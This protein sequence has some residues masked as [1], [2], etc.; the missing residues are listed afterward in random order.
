MPMFFTH[1]SMMASMFAKSD[2]EKKLEDAE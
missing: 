2:A 1:R